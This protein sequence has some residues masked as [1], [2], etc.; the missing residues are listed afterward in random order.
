MRLKRFVSLDSHGDTIVEVLIVIMV[1]SVVL[2]SAYGVATRSQ[3]A[4]QQTQEHTQ[5][6]KIAE[7][8][9]EN[10]KAYDGSAIAAD[11][12]CFQPNGTVVTGFGSG[13]INPVVNDDNFSRYPTTCRQIP[14]GG[15]CTS[16][17][18]Y[19]GVSRSPASAD[20]NLYT[21]TVRWDGINGR[22]EEVKLLYRLQPT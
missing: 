16:Y 6:L 19:V 2:V 15:S 14:D 21:V 12:F 9:L 8:Q 3:K 13:S 5:A 7:G 11:K 1:L 20:P 4:N 18:Y 10:L 17:C 22:K